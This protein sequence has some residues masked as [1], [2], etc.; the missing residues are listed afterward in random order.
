[1]LKNNP[2]I[3]LAASLILG[4]SFIAGCRMLGS[5]QLNTQQQEPARLT[6]DS[7]LLTLTEAAILLRITEDQVLNIMKAESAILSNNGIFT[8]ERLP[9]IKVDDQFLINRELLLSWVNTATLEKRVY[10]DNK[11]IHK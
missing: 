6:A 2:F 4:A 1:M 10:M 5:M 11:M 9:F 3:V 8:G 7:P